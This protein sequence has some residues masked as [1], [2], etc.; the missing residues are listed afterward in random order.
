MDVYKYSSGYRTGQS[1]KGKQLPSFQH[2]W[3]T[4]CSIF[5]CTA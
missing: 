2:R 3:R 4:N 5:S 1:H